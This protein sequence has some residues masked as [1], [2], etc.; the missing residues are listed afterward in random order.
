MIT[1]LGLSHLSLCYAAS[2]LKKGHKVN[3]CDFDKPISLFKNKKIIYE[4]NLDKILYKYRNNLLITSNFKSVN[5][6]K[7]I[8]LAKDLETDKLNNSNLSKIKQLLKKIRIYKNRK[9]LVIMSQVPVTFCRNLNWNKK[10]LYHYV[11]T[12]IFGQGVNRAIKP[13][14]II[15]GKYSENQKINPYFK[16]FLMSYKCP[17]IEMNFE[18]SELTKAYINIY[19]ASQVTTTNYLN[20]LSSKFGANWTKIKSALVLDKRIS[21]NSYLNPGLGISGGNIERDL[22]SINSMRKRKKLDYNLTSKFISIS[23]KSKNWPFLKI[24]KFLKKN[25]VVGLLGFTYKENTMSYKNAPSTAAISKIKKSR[26][27]IH[28]GKSKFLDCNNKYKF[29][30]LREVLF[31]SNFI[32]I[33]HNTAKYKNIKFFKYKNIKVIVDPFKIVDIKNLNLSKQKYFNL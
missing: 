25:S 3:I 6:S 26:C 29:R 8:F 30:S 9:I 5:N 2:A 17:L 14:R 13:D 32:I 31:K 27:I 4:N 28:D 21:K 15:I 33:F 10:N 12:L 23:N 11:E 24:K 7:I 16:K 22:V 18:E 19:L 1:Y 20:E